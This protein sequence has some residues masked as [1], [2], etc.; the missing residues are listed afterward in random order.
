MT[1]RPRSAPL[2]YHHGDLREGLV[3]AALAILGKGSAAALTLRA[4]AREAGVSPAAPYR[5]FADRDALVAAVAER[6]FAALFNRMRAAASR[7]QASPERG[8]QEIAIAYLRFALERPAEYRVM[9]GPELSD[10]ARHATLQQTSTRVF[11]LL[12]EGIAGLQRAGRV[13][14]GDVHAMALSAWAL[15][16]G[17]AMLAIDGRHVEGDVAALERLGRT[18]TELLMFGMAAPVAAVAPSRD[19]PVRRRTTRRAARR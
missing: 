1:R 6:G 10:R 16:H 13:R 5:H 3:E 19:A 7:A 4:A 17:L 12:V 14:A 18:A 15:V 9:F 8:L 2:P 11:S